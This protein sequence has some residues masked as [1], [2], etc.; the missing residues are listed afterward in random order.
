MAIKHSAT[1][2]TAQADAV[3]TAVGNAGL[4]RIYSGTRPANVAAAITGSLLAEVTLGSP[5]A[6]GAVSGVLSPT[7]P[8]SDLSADASGTAT[9][10][11]LWKSDG[12]TAVQD[13]DVSTSGADCNLNTVT[14]VVGGVFTITG[15]THTIGNA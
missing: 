6:P 10:Y 7:V 12:T 9:H 2:R 11:R 4:L 5:F 3:T 8:Q 14:L 15:W 1:L 13:G